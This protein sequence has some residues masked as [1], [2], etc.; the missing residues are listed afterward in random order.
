MFQ[1][2]Q[3]ALAHPGGRTAPTSRTTANFNN[4]D[5]H[6]NNV[7]AAAKAR[8]SERRQWQ[9]LLR[10]QPVRQPAAGAAAVPARRPAAAAAAACLPST[11]PATARDGVAYTP[12]RERLCQLGVAAG[13]G[14]AAATPTTSSPHAHAPRR[15]PQVCTLFESIA[16]SGGWW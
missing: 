5:N 9:P 16:S 10:E 4:H 13:S 7:P 14:S 15:V 12:E 2:L 8:C 6:S 1:N 3:P 11:Y